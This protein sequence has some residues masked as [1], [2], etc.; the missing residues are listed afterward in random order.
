MEGLSGGGCLHPKR[1]TA[2]RPVSAPELAV[3]SAGV[4]WPR[5]ARPCRAA[6]RAAKL[7][8]VLDVEQ[9]CELERNAVRV[10]NSPKLEIWRRIWERCASNAGKEA[11]S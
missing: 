1:C 5:S 11:G 8:G 9:L 7:Y 6:P 2:A 3:S 4:S 10:A